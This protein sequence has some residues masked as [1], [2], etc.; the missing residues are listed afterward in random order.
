MYSNRVIYFRLFSRAMLMRSI[1]RLKTENHECPCISLSH[2]AQ[3]YT[4]KMFP[5]TWILREGKRT[6]YVFLV[7]PFCLTFHQLIL[8]DGVIKSWAWDDPARDRG[9]ESSLNPYG[10]HM[11]L[12]GTRTQATVPGASTATELSEIQ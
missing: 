1:S 12:T 2:I 4:C 6:T 11:F 7:S 5:L 10:D 8:L 9:H 3:I